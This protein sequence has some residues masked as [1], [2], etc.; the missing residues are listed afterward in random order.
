MATTHTGLLERIQARSEAVTLLPA[1]GAGRLVQWHC[2]PRTRVQRYELI[3]TIDGSDGAGEIEITS[4]YNGIVRALMLRE[5]E[6][7]SPGT[8]LCYIEPDTPPQRP[9]APARRTQESSPTLSL[10]DSPPPASRPAAAATEPEAEPEPSSPRR[11]TLL[12]DIEALVLERASVPQA[13]ATPARQK[14][15]PRTV[16]K[17][18][19][20]TP[21]QVERVKALVHEVNTEASEWGGPPLSE[22]ELMRAAIELLDSLSTRALLAIVQENRAREKEEGY[23]TG[24]PR[25]TRYT[26]EEG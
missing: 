23:G 24:W 11:S 19:R 2:K 1:I 16:A 9:R 13:P 22:S 10:P 8:V 26:K 3:A 14:K 7:V 12:P 20:V 21:G 25:P 18:Y 17:V 5:G 4:P 15:Q 6:L